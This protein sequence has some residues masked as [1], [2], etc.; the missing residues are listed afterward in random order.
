MAI[1]VLKISTRTGKTLA[2][3]TTSRD[4]G[5]YTII[6]HTRLQEGV[7]KTTMIGLIFTRKNTTTSKHQGNRSLAPV[8]P[9]LLDPN[10]ISMK[11]TEAHSIRKSIIL[12]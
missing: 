7:T 4:T 8:L 1:G 3:L 9:K 10:Q 12:R 6:Q 5:M 11:T 2:N